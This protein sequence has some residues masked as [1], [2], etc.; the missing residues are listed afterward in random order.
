M[1]SVAGIVRGLPGT[2]GGLVFALAVHMLLVLLRVLVEKGHQRTLRDN[3]ETITIV[4]SEQ[5]FTFHFQTYGGTQS[6]NLLAIAPAGADV[7]D[8]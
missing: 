5:R 4:T 2:V 7:P 3:G 6:V 1:L 8:N